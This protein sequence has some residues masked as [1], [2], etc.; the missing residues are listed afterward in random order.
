MEQLE[1]DGMPEPVFSTS[2]YDVDA[3]TNAQRKV[4][5]AKA[6]VA[7][8]PDLMGEAARMA[9]DEAAQRGHVGVRWLGEMLRL[10]LHDDGA[11]G[12]SN[13]SVA[14]LA[15]MLCADDPHLCGF[16]DL[17]P[18]ALDAVMGTRA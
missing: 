12:F 15:R 2:G 16:F 17:R 8:H 10:W 14:V 11:D 4:D 18:C 7:E 6:L 13:D 5:E 9:A 3:I 1:L